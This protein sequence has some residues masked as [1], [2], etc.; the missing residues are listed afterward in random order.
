MEAASA[1]PF[2]PPFSLGTSGPVSIA[3]L[4]MLNVVKRIAV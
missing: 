3:L 1:D 4:Q 2:S